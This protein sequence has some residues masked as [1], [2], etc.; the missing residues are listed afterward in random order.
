MAATGVDGT[1]I[2]Y[3]SAVSSIFDGHGAVASVILDRTALSLDQQ[4]V[5]GNSLLMWAAYFGQ[6][7]VA[8][9]LL[10]RGANTALVNVDG[11]TAVTLARK[12]G[13]FDIVTLLMAYSGN[14]R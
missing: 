9:D 14:A 7:A 4:G 12:Q 1:S 10:K 11:D 2:F 13:Y 3:S 6:L 8:Q 5:T